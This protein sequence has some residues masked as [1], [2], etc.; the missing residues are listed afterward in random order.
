VTYHSPPEELR[1]LLESLCVA[2]ENVRECFSYATLDVHLVDNAEAPTLDVRE[3]GLTAER[4]LAA[5]MSLTLHQGYGNVGYGAG[6]NRVLAKLDSDYHLLLNSDVEM[7]TESLIQALD[8]LNSIPTD[9]SN[10]GD[11]ALLP[12]LISPAATDF[13]GNK[14]HLCKTYP[15]LFIFWLRGFAPPFMRRQFSRRLAAYER[16]DL[17][18]RPSIK[19]AAPRAA[20]VQIA[21]GC[22]MLCDTALLQESGGFDPRFFLYFEDFDLSLRL[23]KLRPV[24]YLR[25]MKIRHGGGNAAAKGR[26]HQRYFLS[27]AA[28]FFNKH[29]WRLF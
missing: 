7:A 25:A 15:S 20:E 12:A 23:G 6:H 4:L 21:S 2:A 26:D 10:P 5:G 19:D 18:S 29:G 28:R 27:S 17:D 1:R 11:R 16:R 13:L 9:L 14:Q 3:C 8:Y 24:V 22:C